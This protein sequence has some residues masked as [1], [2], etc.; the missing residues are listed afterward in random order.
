MARDEVQHVVQETDAGGDEGGS[1]AV[2]IQ[3]DADVGF[4]GFAMKRRCSGHLIYRWRLICFIR[5]SISLFVP[6]VMR[7]KPGPM[8]LLRSRSKMPWR[9]S[10][11][12]SSGPL[13]PKLAKR[14][15]P[16]LG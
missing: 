9:S 16:A 11:L 14:K 3:A 5:R 1:A 8:S 10:F 13:G 6:M 2:E 12:N 15:L 4:V 7:T